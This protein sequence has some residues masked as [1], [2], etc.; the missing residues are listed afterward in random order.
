M[1]ALVS[2]LT[3]ERLLAELVVFKLVEL[4]QL[5]L[6]GEARF[7]PWASEEVER[8]TMSLRRAELE[9]AVL[10]SGLAKERGLADDVR[11]SELVDDVAE[12]WR[13][14]LVEQSD[15]LRGLLGE[16]TDLTAA[17]RRLADTGLRGVTDLLGR[18]AGGE[19]GDGL[20]LYGRTGRRESAARTPR[21]AQ[22]L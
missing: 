5:L 2:L 13:S 1:E 14:V 21:V 8:A 10:V 12:P 19:T 15:L 9:R 20:V 4:R 7:L 6:A 22:S 16:A 18:T 11:L 17:V 3:R